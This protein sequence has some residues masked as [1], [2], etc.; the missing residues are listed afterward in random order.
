MKGLLLAAKRVELY[1]WRTEAW[2]AWLS[3]LPVRFQLTTTTSP[4]VILFV[5]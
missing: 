4:L 2:K 3:A 1:F 5:R